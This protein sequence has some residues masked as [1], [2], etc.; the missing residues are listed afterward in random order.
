MNFE[1]A[2]RQNVRM[3]MALCGQSG[4]GKTYGSLLIAKGLVKDM[5]KVGVIQTEKGRA[6]CYLKAFP[7]F[8]V[9]NLEPDF[10]PEKF[11]EAI[12]I[13]EKKDLKVLI[14]DSLS[15]EWRGTGGI[16]PQYEK[17]K[18][19]AKHPATV[20]AKLT[21]R[22]DALF[23]KILESQCHILT[24]VKKYIK[25]DM[26]N[27]TS[28]LVNMERPNTEYQWIVQLDLD[29]GNTATVVK[30]NT[31]LFQGKGKFKITEDVGGA[32]RDWCLN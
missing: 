20:W 24:T 8:K 18:A 14:I 3:K 12:C 21:P 11:I 19:T 26:R 25:L 32:I 7:G 6:E 10:T 9:L 2:T 15:D 30:D 28:A 13:G 1:D 4:T 16:Y 23:N 17:M 5:S 22:H 27:N 29:K 31:S